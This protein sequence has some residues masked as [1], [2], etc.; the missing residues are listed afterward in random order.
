MKNIENLKNRKVAYTAG[1]RLLNQPLYGGS[2]EQVN[3]GIPDDN[4][5]QKDYLVVLDEVDNI[6]AGDLLNKVVYEV[7]ASLYNAD[8]NEIIKRH[9]SHMEQKVEA[10]QINPDKYTEDECIVARVAT[11]LGINQFNQNVNIINEA[12]IKQNMENVRNTL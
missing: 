3:T 7:L 10:L 12:C 2:S 11:I 4:K 8:V 5:L 6:L 9:K 1:L